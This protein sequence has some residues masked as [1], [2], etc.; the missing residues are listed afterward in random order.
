MW[1]FESLWQTVIWYRQCCY[2]E[3]TFVRKDKDQYWPLYFSLCL[4][5]N[6]CDCYELT[7]P[8]LRLYMYMDAV[9]Y[10]FYIDA[11]LFQDAWWK[12]S[13]GVPQERRSNREPMYGSISAS[14]A[15]CWTP[16]S[17]YLL[18]WEEKWSGTC[19]NI[20]II[21][22]HVTNDTLSVW[23]HSTLC[24]QILFWS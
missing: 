16:E 11:S 15:V 7:V 8:R 10:S 21:M 1:T 20:F 24:E 9:V 19:W 5:A 4:Y 3:V 23:H 2:P 13:S 17:L 6:N 22:V 14:S 18:L 12:A